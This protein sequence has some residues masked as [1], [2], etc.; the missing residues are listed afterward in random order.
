M[1]ELSFKVGFANPCICYNPE[2]Q[3]RVF[4]HGDDF[5]CEGEREKVQDFQKA[6]SERFLAKHGATLGWGLG[7]EKEVSILNRLVGL[8]GSSGSDNEARI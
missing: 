7:D 8:T 1:K 3:V 5:A 4:R 2:T 6:L